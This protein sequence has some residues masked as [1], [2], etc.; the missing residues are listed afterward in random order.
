MF[1]GI[2]TALV[3]PFRDGEIDEQALRA[4]VARQIDAG[5]TGLVPC[6]S[7]GESATLSHVEHRRVV[8]IVVHTHVN[9]HKVCAGVGRQHI[10]GRAARKHVPHHLGSNFTRI[11]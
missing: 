9:H 6:G 10:D 11:G 2:L 7:T 3:T 8:E 4:M 1:E 5:V